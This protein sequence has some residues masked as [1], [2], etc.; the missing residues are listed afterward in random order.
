MS[1]RA[2]IGLS[3]IVRLVKEYSTVYPIELFS[4]FAIYF[5]NYLEDPLKSFI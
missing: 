2:D 1:S 5:S 3:K 4:Y